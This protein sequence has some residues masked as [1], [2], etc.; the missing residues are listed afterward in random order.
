MSLRSSYSLLLLTLMLRALP[1]PPCQMR[2]TGEVSG[3]VGG[4]AVPFPSVPEPQVSQGICVSPAQP[5]LSPPWGCGCGSPCRNRGGLGPAPS[6][7]CLKKGWE[8]WE[9]HHC[10]EIF[11][12]YMWI[13]G[14]LSA[15]HRVLEGKKTLSS[16]S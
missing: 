12:H 2:Q 10:F 1:P 13:E 11:I 5:V 6:S 9:Q 15:K 8:T 14:T 3:T 4:R 16:N 7:F